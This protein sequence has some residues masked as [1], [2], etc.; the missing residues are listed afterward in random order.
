MCIVA[1]VADDA[2]SVTVLGFTY[3]RYRDCPRSQP[4]LAAEDDLNP[5]G[6]EEGL[7]P[8]QPAGQRA[9]TFGPPRPVG[10][11]LQKV[12]C[13]ASP[14]RLLGHELAHAGRHGIGV[15]DV[16]DRVAPVVGIG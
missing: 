7:R 8:A 10:A 2:D 4:T 12:R 16:L 6:A 14:L 9:G 3:G 5:E 13:A 11:E 15:D 1:D